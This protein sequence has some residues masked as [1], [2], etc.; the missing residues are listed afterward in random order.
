MNESEAAAWAKINK[1]TVA[2][3]IVAAGLKMDE[4]LAIIM[5]GIPGAGKTE[6]LSHIVEGLPGIVVIDLDDIVGRFPGYRP[7]EYY[8]YRKAANII[9]SASLTR[10]L[11]NRIS[12]ALD[13]TFAHEKGRENID[14]A[15]KRGYSVSLFFV[16]QNPEFAWSITEA[17][18][19]ITGRPIERE[20]FQR[21]CDNVIPNVLDTI[22][23]FRHNNKFDVSIK[24]NPDSE[25]TNILTTSFQ[26]KNI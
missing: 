8:R 6:F 17:R 24:I 3:N 5:A 15:L 1:R 19:R 13:G 16:N 20:G 9:I 23:K 7:E 14:R 12:F 2:D 11:R 18:R 21:A 22:R 26:L 10:V 4:P 25:Y